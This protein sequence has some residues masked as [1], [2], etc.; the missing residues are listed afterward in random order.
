KPQPGKTVINCS[1]DTVEE[2]LKA[3]RSGRPTVYAAPHH[4]DAKMDVHDG[5]RFVRCPAETNKGVQCANCGGAKGPICARGDR[6][7]IVKFVAHGTKKR[8][9]D[10]AKRHGGC[11]AAFG[12]T[13]WQWSAARKTDQEKSDAEIL[14]SW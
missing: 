12:P 9:A 6:D 3:F 13:S 14:R 2:A 4:E 7:F 10:P 1:T 8:K 5:V 11:Y